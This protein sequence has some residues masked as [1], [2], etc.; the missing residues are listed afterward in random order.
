MKVKYSCVQRGRKP[1]N[2]KEYN[3]RLVLSLFRGLGSTTIAAV[4]DMT[5][6]SKTTI[7]KIFS[8]MAD[9][10]IIIPVGQGDSTAEGGK[11][12]V[13]F[14]LNPVFCYT[15]LITA[16]LANVIKCSIYNF[17]E[18]CVYEKSEEISVDT[19]YQDALELIAAMILEA[20]EANEMAS[21]QVCGIAI[22]YDGIVNY[23]EGIILDSVYHNWGSGL[24]I[25][26]D[27]AGLLPFDKLIIV[28]NATHF[29]GYSETVRRRNDTPD[30][31]IITWDENRMLGWSLL[32]G[33]ELVS[34]NNGISGAFS[35][36]IIDTRATLNCRCGAKGCLEAVLSLEALCEYIKKNRN[37]YPNSDLVEKYD[38]GRF[39]IKDIFI[40]AGCGDH[41]AHA[42]MSQIA[43]YFAILI[44]NVYTLFGVQKVVF[45]GIFSLS[46]ELFLDMM[47]KKLLNFNKLNLFKREDIDLVYSRYSY[48]QKEAG[49]NPYLKG[50]AM[51]LSDMY[52]NECEK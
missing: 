16:G 2:I 48:N 40:D 13:L 19:E 3:T 44:Y 45:Q 49:K 15:I 47:R 10:A 42:L 24:H 50:A 29:S 39:E 31:M 26:E 8:W 1:S 28:D 30:K 27:L 38:D 11:K 7:S 17:A 37:E 32:K 41:L 35:H 12:P 6:L 22:L 46:G 21:S 9:D 36:I 25:C 43:E 51:L 23:R 4:S 33:N 20:M 34:S 18:E 14:A 52:I 5:G